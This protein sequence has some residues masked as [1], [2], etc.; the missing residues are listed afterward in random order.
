V[1]EPFSRCELLRDREDPRNAEAVVD[2][3]SERGVPSARVRA[4]IGK[5]L[6]VRARHPGSRAPG[7]EGTAERSDARGGR[8]TKG[9]VQASGEVVLG[10]ARSTTG[11]LTSERR[12]MRPSA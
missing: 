10:E 6:V 3:G 12:A 9:R 2:A 1:D 7:L 11:V 5:S 4:S 8:K